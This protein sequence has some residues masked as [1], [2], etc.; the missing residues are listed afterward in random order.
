MLKLCKKNV[1]QNEIRLTT[2]RKRF[3]VEN[4]NEMRYFL[5]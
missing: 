3:R 4:F 2:Y 5:M 1:F